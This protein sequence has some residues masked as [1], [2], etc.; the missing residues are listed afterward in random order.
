MKKANESVIEKQFKIFD[1]MLEG[2]TVYK[3]I[4]DDKGKIIDGILKYL[5]PATVET[6]DFNPEDAIGKSA[7]ELVGSDFI[8]PYIESINEFLVKGEF[9][10]F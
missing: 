7:G 8:K 9:K 2:I 10:R 3:L 5:N 1:K 4:S 6:L